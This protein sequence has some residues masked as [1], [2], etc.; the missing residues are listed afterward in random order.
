[1]AKKTPAPETSQKKPCYGPNEV[2]I[3]PLVLRISPLG[4]RGKLDPGLLINPADVAPA[5]NVRGY[6]LP[7]DDTSH[8]PPP[9]ASE[10][11]PL[12]GS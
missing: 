9:G 11:S 5:R 6:W 7:G 3:D 10:P 4:G 12:N 2:G 8:L 1:M